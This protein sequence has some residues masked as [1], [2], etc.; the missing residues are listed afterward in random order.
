MLD[1][2]L[3]PFPVWGAVVN[4]VTKQLQILGGILLL[5]MLIVAGVVYNDSRES[6]F[7]G[8][9]ISTAGEMRMLSQRI[10]KSSYRALQGDAVAF[11]QLRD[12]RDLFASDLERLATGGELAGTTIPAPDDV[13]S[14]LQALTKIWGETDKNMLQLLAF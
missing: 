9:Y 7:G 5:V 13:H 4:T 10:A 8:V 3:A 2:A 14:Q 12:S 6:T 1:L 11:K